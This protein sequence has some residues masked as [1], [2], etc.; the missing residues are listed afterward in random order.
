MPRPRQH[1]N[2]KR[3]GTLTLLETAALD[4]ID[5]GQSYSTASYL[6]TY[7]TQRPLY[8]FDPARPKAGVIPDLAEGVPQI[9]D[10]AKRVEVHLRAGVRFS[11]PVNREV[12][13]ADVKYAMERAFTP[14][15]ENPYVHTYF[16]DIVGA[17]A[18]AAG[19]SRDISGIEVRGYLTLIRYSFD[20]GKG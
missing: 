13:A 14:A 5:P 19:R 2:G 10:G 18:F 1:Y 6:V 7:A 16:S 3:G 17:Q 15:V 12:R 20:L 11:P 9:S 8:G 4:S